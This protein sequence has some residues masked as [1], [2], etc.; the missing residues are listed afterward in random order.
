MSFSVEIKIDEHGEIRLG[1]KSGG[2]HLPKGRLVISGHVPTP[3]TSPV[4]TL[5]V[6]QYSL[7]TEKN[8]VGEY[9]ASATSNYKKD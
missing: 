4:A 5:S 7:P 1:E 6:T 3:G 8:P 9:V 2:E